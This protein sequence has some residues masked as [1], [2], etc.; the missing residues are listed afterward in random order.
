MFDFKN[1]MLG[2]VVVAL[3]IAGALFISYFAGVDETQNEVMKYEYMTDISSLFEYDTEPTYIEYDPTTNYTGYYSTNSHSQELNKDFFAIEEVDF[4]P[5]NYVNNY[6]IVQKPIVG[7]L[8][9]MDI[10]DSSAS[11]LSRYAVRWYYSDS[12]LTSD[13]Y[14]WRGDPIRLK[15]FI[16]GLNL[17]PEITNVTIQIATN[18]NWDATP[19]GN[20]I[21]LDTFLIIPKSQF[22]FL[23]SGWDIVW[24]T[25]P[26][27][28]LDKDM[29]GHKVYHPYRSF[30]IDLKTGYTKCYESDDMKGTWTQ[31]NTND[32]IL[33]YGDSTYQVDGQH[34]NLSDIISYQTFVY[35]PNQYLDPNDGVRLE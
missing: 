9:Q 12:T 28:N 2:V 30:D 32:L 34:V 15:A 1:G 10:D 20:K 23:S 27:I 35:Y 19:S 6:T 7:D 22:D 31:V 17:D 33:C 24:M 8:E 25:S 5:S 26:S 13:A 11:T 29:Y 21:E 18:T 4:T 3:A 16:D 14:D